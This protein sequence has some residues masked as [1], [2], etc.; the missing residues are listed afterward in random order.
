MVHDPCP[1]SLQTAANS[2][3]LVQ[4]ISQDPDAFKAFNTDTPSL[5]VEIIKDSLHRLYKKM[6][7]ILLVSDDST[8]ATQDSG[9][10]IF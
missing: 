8:H 1:K 9:M 2:T 5:D 3:Q 4:S 10:V 6:V 7:T